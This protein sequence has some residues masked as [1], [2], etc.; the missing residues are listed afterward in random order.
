MMIPV[1]KLQETRRNE[2]YEEFARKSNPPIICGSLIDTRTSAC[3]NIIFDYWRER[4]ITSA[5]EAWE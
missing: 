1:P 2:R 4:K 5:G 3:E